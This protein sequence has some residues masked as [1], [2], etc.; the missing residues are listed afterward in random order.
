MSKTA[1]RRKQQM[2]QMKRNLEGKRRV[3]LLETREKKWLKK[4]D[5]G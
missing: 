5:G 2:T 4:R 3:K 1:E